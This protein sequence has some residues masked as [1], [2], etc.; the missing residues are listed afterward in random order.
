[1]LYP[2]ELRARAGLAYTS[3]LDL[4]TGT[5]RDTSPTGAACCGTATTSR[6]TAEV[7]CDGSRWL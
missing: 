4:L 6:S 2:A 5:L 7:R 1:M 3:L